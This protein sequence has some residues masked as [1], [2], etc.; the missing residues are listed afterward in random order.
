MSYFYLMQAVNSGDL[1]QRDLGAATQ[2]VEPPASFCARLRARRRKRNSERYAIQQMKQPEDQFA[3]VSSAYR[4]SGIAVENDL[5]LAEPLRLTR[6]HI[7]RL[8][9]PSAQLL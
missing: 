4:K 8:Q 1:S 7:K 3:Q 5:R 6:G 2:P 9:H